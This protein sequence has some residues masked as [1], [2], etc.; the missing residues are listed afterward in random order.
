MIYIRRLR[1]EAWNIEHIA[2]HKVI[3]EEVEQVCHGNSLVQRGNK[4]RVVL[5]GPAGPRML[6]VVL[7][8]EGQ[9]VYYPVTAHPASKKDR[10]LYQ[11]EKEKK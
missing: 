6:E 7:N 9:G 1:W 10:R 4:G 3:P 11:E 5:I 8:H 2:R